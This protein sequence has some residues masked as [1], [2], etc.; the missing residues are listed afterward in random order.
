MVKSTKLTILWILVIVLGLGFFGLAARQRSYNL[1]QDTHQSR[2]EAS[3]GEASEQSRPQ[4]KTLISEPYFDTSRE[5]LQSLWRHL[6][7]LSGLMGTKRYLVIF[8][9]SM[10]LRPTGGFIGSFGVVTVDKGKIAQFDF[11]DTT[12]FDYKGNL[13]G[14]T[15]KSPWPIK[16]YLD[17]PYWG[18]RDANWS[19]DFPT[20]A[21]K[22]VKF[23]K[24]QGGKG[25]FDAVIALTPAVL[26]HLLEF[27]GPVKLEGIEGVF[28]SE[29]VLDKLLYKVEKEF[30]Q[31]DIPRQ[32]RKDV[33]ARLARKLI[34]ETKHWSPLKWPQLLEVIKESLAQKEIQIFFF[35]KNLQQ[36][37]A[38]LGWAGEVVDN[39]GDYLFV[40]DANLGALKSDPY[41]KRSI[42]YEVDFTENKRPKVH[43]EITYNH[44]ATKYNWR[45]TDY[46]TFVR[47]YC[48]K[49]SWLTDSS[50]L[51]S[52]VSFMDELEKTVFGAWVKVP[53]GKTKTIAFDY[54][55]P[56]EIN[57]DSYQLIIQKQAGIDDL[58]FEI[59]LKLPQKTYQ[60]EF[61][62]KQDSSV[63]LK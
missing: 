2:L 50:G 63:R 29:N 49:G 43:L 54:L 60:R 59:I 15:V 30:W 53:L 35:D 17:A 48:P 18:M 20:S 25:S 1:S 22:I 21:Q 51:N 8:Q 33:M 13:P 10:E 62:I 37:I 7:S 47:I 4:S 52:E 44:T 28:T 56:Q 32:Q 57:K 58:P 38:N 27:T 14:G 31:K 23:Y 3:L 34:A 26:Q 24:K 6:P 61:T 40:V 45:T 12:V 9:N 36:K 41:I 5:N 46:K 42:T 16:K 19:P 11:Y 39:K 55:L